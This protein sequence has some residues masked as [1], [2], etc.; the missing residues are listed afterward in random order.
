MIKRLGVEVGEPYQ[1]KTYATSGNTEAVRKGFE[2][3]GYVK[4]PDLYT[5]D[6]LATAVAAEREDCAAVCEE[7]V[8]EHA[9]RADL[10]ADQCAKAVRNRS[11]T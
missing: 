1:R 9:G 5:A 6:Q 8:L 10:T 7:L 2:V 4:T 3:G 11:T